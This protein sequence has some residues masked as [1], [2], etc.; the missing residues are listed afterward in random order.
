MADQS[1]GAVSQG[2]NGNV[3]RFLAN[4]PY[5]QHP[6]EGYTHQHDPGGAV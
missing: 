1:I 4:F 6:N 3:E 5:L 2:I